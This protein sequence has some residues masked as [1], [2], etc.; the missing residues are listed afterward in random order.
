MGLKA[1]MDIRVLVQGE[2]MMIWC[3]LVHLVNVADFYLCNEV[4]YKLSKVIWMVKFGLL[5]G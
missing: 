2:S 5:F 1:Y 4:Y 3:G